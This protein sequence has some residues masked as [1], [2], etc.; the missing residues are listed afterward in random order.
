MTGFPREYVLEHEQI[1]FALY[2]IKA[3]RL[4]ASAAAIAEKMRSTAS[5]P[6]EAQTR[7]QETLE[8]HMAEISEELIE[9]NRE[10][11]EDTSLGYKPERQKAWLERVTSE[12]AETRQ[13]ADG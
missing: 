4:N 7:A 12:L 13:W 9:Q 11:D 6:E 2:E 8:E 1:H 3:R 10:F 5:T